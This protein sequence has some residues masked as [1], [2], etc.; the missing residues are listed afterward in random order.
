M[1]NNDRKEIST[2]KF[3]L[4]LVTLILIFKPVRMHINS[5]LDT[6]LFGW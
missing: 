5:I 3:F 4:N 6:L 1:K 2:V